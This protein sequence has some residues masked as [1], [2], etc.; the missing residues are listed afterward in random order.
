MRNTGEII[1]PLD[2]NDTGV[3]NGERMIKNIAMSN[4]LN[5]VNQ[6]D[7]PYHVFLTYWPNKFALTQKE[8][9][10]L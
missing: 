4:Y 2:M 1:T 9:R 8:Q 5:Q 6:G 10:K 7:E 3:D